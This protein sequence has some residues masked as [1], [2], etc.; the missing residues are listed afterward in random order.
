MIKK[1]TVFII[2]LN[3]A[4]AV[5]VILAFDY[6]LFV[7]DSFRFSYV[8]EHNLPVFEKGRK[9][10]EICDRKYFTYLHPFIESIY[11]LKFRDRITAES[12]DMGLLIC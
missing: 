2:L 5:L 12:K 7:K 3:L 11:R 10:K 9:F 6:A 8:K 1:K 4:A